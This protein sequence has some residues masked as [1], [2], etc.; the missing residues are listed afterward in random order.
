MNKSVFNFAIFSISFMSQALKECLQNSF[1]EQEEIDDCAIEVLAYLKAAED[2]S[3][4][5]KEC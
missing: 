1:I 5:E 3:E 4:S 2:N